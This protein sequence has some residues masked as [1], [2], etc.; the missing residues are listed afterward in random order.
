MQLPPTSE[1]S[2]PPDA[3]PC[4]H[5]CPQARGCHAA[6]LVQHALPAGGPQRSVRL[7]KGQPLYL[8][9]DPV[10]AL[11]AVR[12]GTVKTHVST[13]DGRTQVVGFHF[14]GE[15]VGLDSL[16]RTR[17][18][19]YATALEDTML[20]MIA[21]DLRGVATA[22][23]P[24]L[25]GLLFLALDCQAQRARAMQTMLA[26]M[27]AEERLVTF[28]LWMADGFAARGFSSSAFIL[29]M[30]REEIGSYVGLTLETVSRQFSR[31]AEIGLIRVRHRCVE[32]LD[33]PALR[34]IAERP[35]ISAYTATDTAA[36]S[37]APVQ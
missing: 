26:L 5:S 16:A 18:V 32:L 7:R 37:A 25:A 11:Y 1:R 21:V 8:I 35:T 10:T 22:A 17:Y 9:G 34:A 31:L 4:C 3:Q 29:R 24:A 33:K 27:T 13:E 23:A 19:S 28:L 30:S 6:S 14:P 15:L 20:C 2:A 36:D 12:V